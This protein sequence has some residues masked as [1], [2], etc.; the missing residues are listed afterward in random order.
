MKPP[1]KLTMSLSDELPKETKKDVGSSGSSLS[2]KQSITRV[3]S[4]HHEK[5]FGIRREEILTR[6]ISSK[7]L[8]GVY[9]FTIIIG[10]F[11]SIVETRCLSVFASYATD[12]YSQHSLLSTIGVVRAVI[13]AAALPMFAKLSDLFGRTPLFL[14]AMVSRIIGLVVMSQATNIQRYSGGMVFYSIGWSGSRMMFQFNLSDASSLRWRLLSLTMLNLPVII[15]TWAIGYITSSLLNK[16]D[17]HFGIA[18]WAFTF[19]LSTVPYLSFT[20][21]MYWK[22]LKT[23]EWAQLKREVAESNQGISISSRF[24][25]KCKDVFWKVDLL[26]CFL[27]V[28]F[29]GL[30]LVPLTLAGGESTKWKSA[31]ILAPLICGFACLVVFIFWEA[32][33]ARHPLIPFVLMK[34]R[35]V[36]A[37]FIIG[38]FYTFAYSMPT[39]YSY[40]VL[41]VGMNASTVVATRT[42]ALASFAT[43]F[44]LPFVGLAVARI[45]RTKAFII[46]GACVWFISM[47][48]F[49]HFRG[50]NNGVDGKYFRDGVAAS[51]VLLGFGI[52]FMN[53]LLSVSAQTCTNHE[54][55]AS[56]SAMF[57]ALYQT[58]NAIGDCVSGAIWTQTMY[59]RIKEKME[60]Y[61]VN[62]S[63]AAA[64]Y[65][66]PY[67]F[68]K[69]YKWGTQERICVVLAYAEVQKNLCVVGLCLCV[70]LLVFTFF[71]R[72]HFLTEQQSLDDFVDEKGNIKSE[73]RIIF[74]NDD[75]KILNFM[76]KAVGRGDKKVTEDVKV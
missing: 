52:A 30:I 44:T 62:T 45:R 41:L 17:W 46:F 16:Y 56:V 68:A 15:T 67:K 26:G 25:R 29:L 69:S 51:M 18:L 49:V 54:Y 37:A 4:Q 66:T 60:L 32:K 11:V 6:Q 21:F 64:A 76:K 13:A 38:I 9:F 34:D 43:S 24:V 22:A 33:M 39:S 19:P 7:L 71:L 31:S 42:P 55:M 1:T 27:V 2:S 8:T 20:G 3:D 10:M 59:Q 48:L 5:S 75:D 70:P 74:K 65:K 61:G 72:D 23:D 28:A 50:D 35:G 47:G 63:L 36:W 14:F 53:R 73:G 57:A 12:S 40:P 58:G